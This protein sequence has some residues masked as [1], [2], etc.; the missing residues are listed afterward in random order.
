[1]ID[2]V[3]NL[4]ELDEKK[5]NGKYLDS[6]KWSQLQKIKQ[7]LNHHLLN[8]LGSILIN[9]SNINNQYLS[10]PLIDYNQLLTEYNIIIS[11]TKTTDHETVFLSSDSNPQQSWPLLEK[12]RNLG[13]DDYDFA[14]EDPEIMKFHRGER[15]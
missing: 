5:Y 11:K 12:M 3:R 10:Q 1:M 4:I 6:L 15:D 2:S 9:Y 13:A 7:R 14:R 8:S